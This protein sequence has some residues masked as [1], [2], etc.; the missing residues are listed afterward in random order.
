MT[1]RIVINLTAVTIAALALFIMPRLSSGVGLPLIII[2]ALI[3]GIFV[4]VR[5]H[6]RHTAYRCPA[7][8]QVFDVSAWTDFMSPHLG[9]QKMLQCPYCRTSAWCLE[10]D[11]GE[12]FDHPHV[13]PSHLRPSQPA[14][15]SLYIQIAVILALYIVLWIITISAPTMTDETILER[16][17]IPLAAGILALLHFVFC[18]YAL[19]RRYRSRIYLLVT[20]FVGAF[21]AL[22]IWIQHSRLLQI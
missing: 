21:I 14:G 22:A 4:L 2:A 13:T 20:I 10:V 11:R 7:C 12:I 9:G 16:V 19:R 15:T 1:N 17:K 5:W 8:N 18:L 3:V 6:A